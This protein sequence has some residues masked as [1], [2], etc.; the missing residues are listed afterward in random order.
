MASLLCSG[1]GIP[2]NNTYLISF[3]AYLFSFVFKKFLRNP[4]MGPFKT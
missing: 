1:I 2:V 4:A 3:K